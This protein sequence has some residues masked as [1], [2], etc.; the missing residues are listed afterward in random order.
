MQGRL[1][2]V[3][4]EPATI[5]EIKDY[6]D[7]VKTE[8]LD[9][10]QEDFDPVAVDLDAVAPD[11]ELSLFEQFL[12]EWYRLFLQLFRIAQKFVQLTAYLIRKLIDHLRR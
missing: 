12:R 7:Q 9:S 5:I 10:G 3:Y 8:G 4:C 2:F 1:M 11:Q 6:I